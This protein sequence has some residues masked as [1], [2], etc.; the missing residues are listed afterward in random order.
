MALSLFSV[1]AVSQA[2]DNC[3][4]LWRKYDSLSSNMVGLV[5][6]ESPPT[7]YRDFKIFYQRLVEQTAGMNDQGKVFVRFVVDTLGN[8]QCAKV[9]KS[10]NERL[11]AKALEIIEQTRFSPA[12]QRG[13]RLVAPMMLPITFG[14]PPKKKKGEK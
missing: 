11:N 9:V 6:Y 14:E 4:L 12:T 10:D 3:I 2:F 5:I 7:P 13:K 1:Q 8:A